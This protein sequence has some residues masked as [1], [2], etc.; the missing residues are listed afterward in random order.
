MAFAF[1]ISD[2]L[3]EA[4]KEAD[5]TFLAEFDDPNDDVFENLD[6]PR[7]CTN[8]SCKRPRSPLQPFASGGHSS[9]DVKKQRQIDDPNLGGASEGDDSNFD[10]SPTKPIS[11]VSTETPSKTRDIDFDDFCKKADARASTAKQLKPQNLKCWGC[12]GH[13]DLYCKENKQVTW[14]SSNMPTIFLC[15]ESE[16]YFR[17]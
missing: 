3:A 14:T 9:P 5:P 10:R 6:S 7:S 2:I 8:C 17:L 12:D 16:H 11:K 13:A 15:K 4:V 1:D